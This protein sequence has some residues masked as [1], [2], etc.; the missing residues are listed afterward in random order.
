MKAEIHV[1]IKVAWWVSWYLRA[2]S[3]FAHLTGMQP[4]FEKVSKFIC[5]RGI[6]VRT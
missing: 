4:D 2:L 1:S 3:V 6:K 5:H